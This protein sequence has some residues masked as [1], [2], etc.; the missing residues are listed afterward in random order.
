MCLVRAAT[1]MHTM[2][3]NRERGSGRRET[4]RI[5]AEP[6]SKGARGQA[7]DGG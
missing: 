6:A 4:E 7:D 1:A 3:T 5:V 2:T